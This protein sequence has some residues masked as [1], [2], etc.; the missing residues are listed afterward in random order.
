MSPVLDLRRRQNHQI[1]PVLMQNAATTAIIIPIIEPVPSCFCGLFVAAVLA[2]G[3]IDVSLML[4]V[5]QHKLQTLLAHIQ[6]LSQSS[7]DK[8]VAPRQWPGHVH[9]ACIAV[10]VVVAIVAID[11]AVVEAVVVRIV[12]VDIDIMQGRR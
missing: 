9:A 6:S 11:F 8:H 3:D 10:A 7:F 12:V 5:S 4:P 2:V 1:M